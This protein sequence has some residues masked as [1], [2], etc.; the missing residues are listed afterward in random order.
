MAAQFKIK[1]QPAAKC[2]ISAFIRIKIV[3]YRG[4]YYN[5]DAIECDVC[6]NICVV[7]EGNQNLKKKML[8]KN[9]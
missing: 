3:Y 7:V 4:T 5:L 6:I 9:C 1:N 8:V 2:M